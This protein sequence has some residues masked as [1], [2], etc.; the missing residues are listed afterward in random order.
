[1]SIFRERKQ[2]NNNT[3]QDDDDDDDVQGIEHIDMT[4]CF[5]MKSKDGVI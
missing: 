2:E 5:Q 1:M 3:N 4:E